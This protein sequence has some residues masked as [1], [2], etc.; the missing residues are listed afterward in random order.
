MNKSTIIILTALLFFGGLR[1]FAEAPDRADLVLTHGKVFTANDAAPWAEAVAVTGGRIVAVGTDD[2]IERLIGP[3]TKVLDVRGKLVIPGLID[4]HAHFASGG[5]SLIALS[6][7]GVASIAKVQEMIAAKIR[8]LPA[9]A[10]VSGSAY[11]HTLF[12]GGAWPTK[13]DLDKVSASNPVVIERVDGH[14][15][16]VNSLAL[17]RA[18]ITKETKDPF[19]GEILR[20]PKT[21]EPTGI[22][23]EAAAGLVRIPGPEVDSTPEKDIVRALEH[24]A[25]LGLT[26]VHTDSNFEETEIYR[27]LAGAGKLTL[28][29]YA[30]LPAELLKDCIRNG[31]R[32]GQGDDMVRAGFLKAFIDGTLGSGTALMFAPFA[33]EP[34]KFG[35]PQ[36]PEADFDALVA[37]AHA[38]GFQTGTHAIGDK[39]V[40]WVLNAVERAQRKFG[41]KD[42]RHRIE[43]AQVIA[44]GD[45]ERFAALGVIASMQP[46]HCT[47]DMRFCEARIGKERS[48]GAYAWRSLLD[49][50]ARL[51]FGSDWPV[52]PLDP[53]RG[54]YSAVTRT[55]IEGGFP[56]GGWFPEQRL[57][58]AEAIGLFTKGAAYA[59]FEESVKGTLEPGKLADMVV[60]SKDLF[61]IAPREILTTEALVTILGGRIVFQR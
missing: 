12:P 1:T 49:K 35:L 23:T 18:G 44:P 48:R 26:G 38:N 56:E 8:Q 7:R 43:H 45:L 20:D 27:K 50:G 24:A 11:D 42:L 52:E 5:R 40:N 55:N 25:G 60:L 29:V 47:T 28:R 54:L 31:V 30:W 51:A 39:G 10:L 6:F 36:M 57:T 17:K 59:S 4:A 34:G 58:M 46:T 19:G 41:K 13:E 22:L 2:D 61:T 33:D 9:G 32:Q 14:S 3:G 16:W 53:M 21:G 15:I 37:E